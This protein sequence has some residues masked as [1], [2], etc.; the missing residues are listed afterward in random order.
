MAIISLSL[1]T[2]S[3]TDLIW[4]LTEGIIHNCI[5]APTKQAYFLQMSAFS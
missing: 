4:D 2:Q 3:F 1:L 5:V